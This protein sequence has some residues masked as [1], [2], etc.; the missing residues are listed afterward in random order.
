MRKQQII[1][2]T[3]EAYESGY[4]MAQAYINQPSPKVGTPEYTNLLHRNLQPIYD[5]I[6]ADDEFECARKKQVQQ[7]MQAHRM[8]QS[9]D[10]D[11][12]CN[13]EDGNDEDE[14]NP[15]EV[16]D[17]DEDASY[18]NREDLSN[19]EMDEAEIRSGQR[20]RDD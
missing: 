8:Q 11:T 19:K 13:S 18:K 16:A 15:D 1:D 5:H 20:E 10:A 14:D 3:Q 17:Q 7:I 6:T 9:D 12:E 4:K 2:F